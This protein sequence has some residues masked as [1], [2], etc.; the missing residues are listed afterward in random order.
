M[1]GNG[2]DR[3]GNISDQ[4]KKCE[5]TSVNDHFWMLWVVT[6]N[7]LKIDNIEAKKHDTKSYYAL[8][9]SAMEIV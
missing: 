9:F 6:F 5:F 7:Y 2:S 4:G 8:T 3:P 1:K